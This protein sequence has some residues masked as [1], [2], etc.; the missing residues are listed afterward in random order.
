MVFLLF[1]RWFMKLS[2]GDIVRTNFVDRDSYKKNGI[3]IPYIEDNKGYRPCI[4]LDTIIDDDSLELIVVYG[5]SQHINIFGKDAPDEFS[6]KVNDDFKK[7]PT[8]LP[9]ATKWLLNPENIARLEYNECFFDVKNPL[10]G[11]LNNKK[12]GKLKKMYLSY[13]VQNIIDE[14]LDGHRILPKSLWKDPKYNL[15]K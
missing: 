9:K 15:K 14:L 4:V 10:F 3:I 7:P 1:N 8:N 11:Q 2:F 12:A 13:E 6:L 5:T